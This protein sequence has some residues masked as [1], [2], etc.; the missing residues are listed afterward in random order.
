[1][2]V[3]KRLE[4]GERHLYV[5]RPLS[6]ATSSIRTII[7]N[8]EKIKKLSV[9]LQQLQVNSHVQKATFWRKWSN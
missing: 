5:G 1:M 9:W 8:S 6:L 7:Q 2:E 3:I 4:A